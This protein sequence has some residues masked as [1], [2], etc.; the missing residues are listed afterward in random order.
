MPKYVGEPGPCTCLLYPW[1]HI[2]YSSSALYIRTYS[3]IA[4][5]VGGLVAVYELAVSGLHARDVPVEITVTTPGVQ[6]AVSCEDHVTA[7]LIFRADIKAVAGYQYPLGVLKRTVLVDSMHPHN[8]LQIVVCPMVAVLGRGNCK[9]DDV[10]KL[11]SETKNGVLY[12]VQSLIGMIK[13]PHGDFSSTKG[14]WNRG[15]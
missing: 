8:V 6:L 10:L 7:P 3:Y 2:G 9:L 5:S 12:Y 13:I 1:G 15:F 4:I 14:R 11:R